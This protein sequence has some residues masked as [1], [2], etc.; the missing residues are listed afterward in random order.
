MARFMGVVHPK[1]SFPFTYMFDNNDL[2][3]LIISLVPVKNA[4]LK[5]IATRGP[6]R[7]LHNVGLILWSPYPMSFTWWMQLLSLDRE[8]LLTTL[9]VWIN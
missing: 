7:S 3:I 9:I 6:R 4:L 1:V 2:I 8:T 5:G